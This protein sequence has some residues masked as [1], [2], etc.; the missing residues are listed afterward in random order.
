MV[1]ASGWHGGSGGGCA[2]TN[3]R[4]GG[5]IW[6]KTPNPSHCGSVSGVL[7][8]KAVAGGAGRWLVQENSTEM[9]VGLHVR[10]REARGQVLGQNPE[11]ERLWLGYGHAM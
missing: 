7:C 4:P 6:A 3:E 10:Q 2:F 5:R 11:I 1:G 8:K 9:A